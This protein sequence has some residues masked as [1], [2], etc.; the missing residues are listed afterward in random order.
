VNK[1][2]GLGIGKIP[3][4]DEMEEGPCRLFRATPTAGRRSSP[5]LRG[6]CPP[7]RLPAER[8]S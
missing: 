4:A 5:S 1:K 7:R 3:M 6:S 8:G 2:V